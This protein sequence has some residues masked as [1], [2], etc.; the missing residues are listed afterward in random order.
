MPWALEAILGSLAQEQ[1]VKSS[2][3]C[4]CQSVWSLTSLPLLGS[5]WITTIEKS[6]AKVG[7]LDFSSSLLPR[8]Q[9]LEFV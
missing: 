1:H 9:N 3:Q 8:H 5:P 2:H 6:P 7:L 4:H